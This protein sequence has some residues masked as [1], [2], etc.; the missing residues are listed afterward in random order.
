MQPQSDLALFERLLEPAARAARRGDP[1]QIK[2]V[3]L[4]LRAAQKKFMREKRPDSPVETVRGMVLA[5]EGILGIVLGC[6]DAD[7]RY[8]TLQRFPYALQVMALVAKKARRS[9][10]SS[11]KI[12]P[13]MSS[14]ELSTLSGVEIER[15]VPLLDALTENHSLTRKKDRQ[16]T[17]F[18]ITPQGARLLEAQW[19]GWQVSRESASA[20]P[21]LRIV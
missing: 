3:L 13:A 17:Y 1:E 15:L 6:A 9:G 16:E 20:V 2:S 10:L 21:E 4:K 12:S 19:P 11:A 18:E 14:K 5:I 7:R 8:E